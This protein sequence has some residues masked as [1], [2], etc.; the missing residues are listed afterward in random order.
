MAVIDVMR[1]NGS[2]QSEI[3]QGS[4]ALWEFATGPTDD[5]HG[6]LSNGNAPSPPRVCRNSCALLALFF[7]ARGYRGQSPAEW[8]ISLRQVQQADRPHV[9]KIPSLPQT[10]RGGRR[11]YRFDYLRRPPSWSRYSPNHS[12]PRSVVKFCH[13]KLTHYPSSRCRFLARSVSAGTQEGF[14]ELGVNRLC[15][16]A[17]DHSCP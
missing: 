9:S 17:A 2:N 13:I 4:D 7:D 14:P 6:K 8:R 5:K 3:W 11:T 1:G 16:Q 12:E 15:H 10:I